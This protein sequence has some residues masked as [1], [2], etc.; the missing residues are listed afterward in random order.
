M[1]KIK[2]EANP[3]PEDLNE[4]LFTYN[5]SLVH[6]KED[7]LQE[8]TDSLSTQCKK[9]DMKISISKTE[10]MKVRRTPS[11]LKISINGTPLKQV[12][13]FKYLTEDEHLNRE[14]ETKVQ[15]ANSVSYQL[16]PLLKHPNIPF[17]TKAKLINSIFISTL[18]YQCQ[19]W[20]LT[21][22]LECKITSCEM[23]CLRRAINKTRQDMIRNTTMREMVGTTPVLHYI[24]RQT[25]RWLGHLTHM[26]PHQLANKAYNKKISGYRARGRPRM[27]SI[28]GVK[29]TLKNHNISPIQAVHLARDRKLFLPSTPKTVQEDG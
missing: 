12:S 21:K 9:L 17:E 19:I 29:E 11:N 27:A 7:Q 28:E 23:R 25:I 1:D 24:Q 13:E 6:E 20:T 22:S 2:K 16:A 15:K 5:Q 14:I 3:N 10:M 4:M 26:A 18:T 8:H